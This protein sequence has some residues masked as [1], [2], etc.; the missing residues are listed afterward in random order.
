MDELT[1]V[2]KN[3]SKGNDED[4]SD[5]EPANV[6]VTSDDEK[7]S[8][9]RHPFQVKDRP[10]VLNI[11][12]KSSGFSPSPNISRTIYIPLNTGFIQ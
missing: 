6:P 1:E 7:D 9:I 3:L 4:S 5:E 10:I 2:C 8:F 11:Q 12:V